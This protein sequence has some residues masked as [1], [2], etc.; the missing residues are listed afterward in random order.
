MILARLNRLGEGK[1]DPRSSVSS[2][3]G[4]ILM[5]ISFFFV[6]WGCT[7]PEVF[8]FFASW[9]KARVDGTPYMCCGQV[10]GARKERPEGR[11]SYTPLLPSYRPQTHWTEPP[12]LS[13]F[14]WL[15]CAPSRSP[16]MTVHEDFTGIK[17][18]VP[19]CDS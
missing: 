1:R 10:D 8:T 15:H 4:Y 11:P 6:C 3:L 18:T 14:S 5:F 9:P 13:W 16:A 7:S 19:S 2:F 12:R 17:I